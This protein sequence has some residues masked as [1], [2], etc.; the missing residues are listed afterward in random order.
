M[1]TTPGTAGQDLKP[2]S[3]IGGCTVEAYIAAGGM[4]KVYRARKKYLD[5]VVAVKVLHHDLAG[6]P[7]Y[8]Q[9][10][11][12]EGKL[13]ANLNHPNLVQVYD[14]GEE[15]GRFY[16]VMEYVEGRDLR[17]VIAKE[18]AMP[19]DKALR[20]VRQVAEALAYAHENG[21]IHRDIKPS[22]IILTKEGNAK[23][24]DLGLARPIRDDSEVT[25]AGQVLGTPVYMSPEQCRGTTVDGRS[26]LYSLG[27]TFYTL[28]CGRPPYRGEAT[29][30]LLHRIIHENPPPLATQVPNLPEKIITFAQRLMAKHPGARFQTAREVVKEIQE[31][32]AGRFRLASEAAAVKNRAEEPEDAPVSWGRLAAFAAAGALIAAGFILWPGRTTSSLTPGG[33]GVSW[34]APAQ[35]GP[36]AAAGDHPA[37]GASGEVET[38]DGEAA[39]AGPL[40]QP[41]SQ[42]SDPELAERL[43]GFRDELNGGSS[44]ELLAYF[45]PSMRDN[46]SLQVALA[47]MLEGL[48]HRELKPVAYLVTQE[49][50]KAAKT[51]VLFRRGADGKLLGITVDWFRKDD[52]W[53]ARPRAYTFPDG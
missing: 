10:F 2:G 37:P 38:I 16:I 7:D 48:A 29:P 32:F 1:T 34:K 14:V 30:V 24:A 47:E 11:L 26:D 21:V 22:N 33:P 17:E 43:E 19:N 49:D 9:R 25:R 13:A 36:K 45:E 41:R 12:R 31:I 46:L 39:F 40:A 52:E 50:E 28:L 20:I 27:V 42:A 44:D 35:T 51:V 18:G 8:L 3:I 4:S 53:Y 5:R 15:N 23:V 6:D